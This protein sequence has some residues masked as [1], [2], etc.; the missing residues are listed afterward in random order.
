MVKFIF[1]VRPGFNSY[2]SFLYLTI[3][4]L[5]T[6]LNQFNKAKSYLEKAESHLRF[7]S[8]PFYNISAQ[9]FIA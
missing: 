2:S 6:F 4:E 5:Y 7:S 3:A 8:D 1:C 9:T